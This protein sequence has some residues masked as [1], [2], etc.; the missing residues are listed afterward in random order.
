MA[1]RFLALGIGHPLSPRRFPVLISVRGGVD[2]GAIV[3]LEGLGQLQNP[4]TSLGL[5]LATFRLVA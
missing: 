5:E 4:M 1:V 3:Q 2:P